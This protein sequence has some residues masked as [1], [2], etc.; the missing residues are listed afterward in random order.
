MSSPEMSSREMTS[1]EGFPIFSGDFLVL[2][3]YFTA[4]T[5]GRRVSPRP[6]VS[7]A[8]ILQLGTINILPALLQ[9]IRI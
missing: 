9:F 8:K 5:Q 1:E 4:E 7:A 3:N 2:Y 6:C